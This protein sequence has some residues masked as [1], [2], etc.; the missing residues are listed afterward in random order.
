MPRSIGTI[1]LATVVALPVNVAAQT[2]E[3][4]LL[5]YKGNGRSTTKPTKT[6]IPSYPR[7]ANTG[8]MIL[9]VTIRPDGKVH[10]VEAIRPLRGATDAGIAAVKRWEF[11]P[12]LFRGKGA[13]A[14][15]DLLIS[16]PWRSHPPAMPRRVDGR[17]KASHAPALPTPV[18]VRT[19]RLTLEPYQLPRA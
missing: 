8:S 11:Q 19:S 1:V 13:W 5:L 7:T 15:L 3:S 2:M 9:E 6:V 12:V 4:P 18:S 14:V 16:N 17:P 10:S